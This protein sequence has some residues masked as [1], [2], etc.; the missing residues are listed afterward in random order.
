MIPPFEQ[1]VYDV[2]DANF[3]AM[4]RAEHKLGVFSHGIKEYVDW[5]VKYYG[6]QDGEIGG[7]AY[8]PLL[9]GS[10]S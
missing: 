6:A 9:V 10:S 2:D 5:K 3:A 7:I 1:N 4:F 8:K